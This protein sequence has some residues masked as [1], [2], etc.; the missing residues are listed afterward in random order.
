MTIRRTM[1]E[2]GRATGHNFQKSP[3]RDT[4]V[5]VREEYHADLGPATC[6]D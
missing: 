6:R 3:A 5:E 4:G 1:A 2:N